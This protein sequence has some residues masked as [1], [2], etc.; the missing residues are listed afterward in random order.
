MVLYGVACRR[1]KLQVTNLMTQLPPQSHNEQGPL[2]SAAAVVSAQVAGTVAS[3]MMQPA[4]PPGGLKSVQGN[5]NSSS[6]SKHLG[7]QSPAAAG[8]LAMDA[9][10][11]AYK[12]SSSGAA[13]AGRVLISS[14]S[15]SKPPAASTAASRGQRSESPPS[16]SIRQQQWWG[17]QPA[18]WEAYYLKQT[19]AA[20]AV[21]AGGFRRAAACLTH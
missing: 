15:I 1:R 3:C 13:A 10:T 16:R 8:A 4:L 11:H 5:D 17:Q 21:G 20:A 12:T 2:P 18:Y 6:S 19:V 9:P 14:G 7:S